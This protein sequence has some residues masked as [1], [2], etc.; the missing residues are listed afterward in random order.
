MHTEAYW[1]ISPPPSGQIGLPYAP[2]SRPVVSRPQSVASLAKP[3]CVQR[4]PLAGFESRAPRS[5]FR[6]GR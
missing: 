5:T 2:S 1:Q 3:S 4:L 6:G